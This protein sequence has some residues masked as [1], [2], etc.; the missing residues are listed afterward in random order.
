MRKIILNLAISID[1]YI[2]DDSGGYEWI[3]GDG[4]NNLNTKLEWDYNKFLNEVDIVVMGRNC[5]EQKM[6]EDFKEKKVYIATSRKEQDFDNCIF[7][8]DDICGVI[9]KERE[10]EGKNIFLFGGGILVDYFIKQNIIDEYI[11]GII[12]TVLGKGKPLFLGNNPIIPLSLKEYFIDNGICI[13][14]YLKK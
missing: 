14:H 3:A 1:G 2:A 11:I 10:K 9:L 13:L 12:P 6:H 4:N 5:Y 7:I 8:N